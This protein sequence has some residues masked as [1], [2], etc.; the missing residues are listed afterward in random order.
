MCVATWRWGYVVRSDTEACTCPTQES[1]VDLLVLAAC[2]PCA[3][4]LAGL[5]SL[6]R[7]VHGEADL[8]DVP[9]ILHAEQLDDHVLRCV[10]RVATGRRWVV[11]SAHGTDEE[12]ELRAMGSGALAV[13]STRVSCELFVARIRALLRLGGR[14]VP[15]AILKGRSLEMGRFRVDL[16]PKRARFVARLLEQRNEYV[17]LSEL[18]PSESA[19]RHMVAEL[20]Q[21]LGEQ[22]WRLETKRCSGIRWCDSDDGPRGT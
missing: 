2:R 22:A 10:A 19:G 20:R 8:F 5:P 21:Q 15:V 14:V 9:A 18:G 16:T 13:W 3:E 1:E 4:Q 6:V 11:L 12:A 17:P 7:V